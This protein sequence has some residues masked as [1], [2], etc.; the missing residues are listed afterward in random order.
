MNQHEDEMRHEFEEWISDPPH[1]K[2]VTRIPNL[3]KYA[4]PGNYR[5]TDVQMAWDAW[6]A[7]AERY[8]RLTQPSTE[9]AT[10]TNT[11]DQQPAPLERLSM[12]IGD[13]EVRTCDEILSDS[14]PHCRASIVKWEGESCIAI[15]HWERSTE[16]FDLRFVGSRPFAYA[17]PMAF[18]KLA[19]VGDDHLREYFKRTSDA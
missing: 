5:E 17:E 7:G 4:W 15:A 13:F 2:D 8:D 16:G 1:H 19:Q 9:K 11:A 10:M 18:W 12:R 6:K 14:G 3:E